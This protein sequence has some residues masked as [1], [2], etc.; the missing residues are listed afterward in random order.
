MTIV[1]AAL[2]TEDTEDTKGSAL[3]FFVC[4]VPSWFFV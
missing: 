1:P 4:F 2:D 3:S